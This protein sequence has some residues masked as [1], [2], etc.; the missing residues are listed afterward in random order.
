MRGTTAN[1]VAAAATAGSVTSFRVVAAATAS[2][3]KAEVKE[4]PGPGRSAPA[5][6]ADDVVIP[7]GR[8]ATGESGEVDEDDAGR[9]RPCMKV[10]TREGE[11][12]LAPSVGGNGAT[13]D[14][15][16]ARTLATISFPLGVDGE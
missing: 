16:E 1:V 12:G 14:G 2:S 8:G 6:D 4:L 11:A 7:P 9:V 5:S 3:G 13:N 15:D 10:R